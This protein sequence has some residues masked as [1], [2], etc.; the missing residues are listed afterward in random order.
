MAASSTQP[1]IVQLAAQDAERLVAPDRQAFFFD[2]GG[3]SPASAA[4]AALT[5]RGYAAPCDLVLEVRDD[6][7]PWNARRLRLVAEPDGTAMCSPTR[8]GTDL[9]LD[10]RVLAAA[11]LGARSL[12]SLVDVAHLE[13]RSAGAVDSLSRAMLSDR[14]ATGSLEF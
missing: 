2:G 9:R 14:P 7:C 12:R 11:Y 13:E 8:R 1:R 6:R 10:V 3:Q 5:A 4:A